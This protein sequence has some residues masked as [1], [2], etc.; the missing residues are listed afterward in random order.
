M[1]CIPRNHRSLL[2]YSF[3]HLQ[4]KNAKLSTPN[5]IYLLASI[6]R[7]ADFKF[8]VMITF[9]CTKFGNGDA[10]I[11]NLKWFK[12]WKSLL[13]P[14]TEKSRLVLASG[15]VW[16]SVL[17]LRGHSCL[18]LHS[19]FASVHFIWRLAVLTVARWMPPAS[20]KLSLHV[21]IQKGRELLLPQSIQQ[22]SF[23]MFW[24]QQLRSCPLLIPMARKIL[25]D[26]WGWATHL[27]LEH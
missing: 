27:S 1:V 5:P 22:K 21:H 14:W 25:W 11:C 3:L 24:L 2:K 8:H 18:S 13:T 23:A 19:V 15:S 7:I 6:H 20:E 10:E 26:I 9:P 17:M 4:T 12:Q 16:S